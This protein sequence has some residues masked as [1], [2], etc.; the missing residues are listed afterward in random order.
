HFG[1][2]SNLSNPYFRNLCKRL[3]IFENIRT[4]PR[5]EHGNCLIIM[6]FRRNNG[7][8]EEHCFFSAHNYSANVCDF[9]CKKEMIELVGSK[10]IRTYSKKITR[11]R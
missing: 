7:S 5:Q 10:D 6:Y 9:T 2:I 8:Q 11:S 1:Y 4:G 3:T